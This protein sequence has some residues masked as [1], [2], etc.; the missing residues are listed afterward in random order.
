LGVIALGLGA[1]A[2][3]ES[4]SSIPPWKEEFFKNT[5]I[6]IVVLTLIYLLVHCFSDDLVINKNNRLIVSGKT[7]SLSIDSPAATA[8]SY[9]IQYF[10]DIIVHVI[11]GVHLIAAGS[12]II[13]SAVE[14]QQSQD[15]DV[16]ISAG[17]RTERNWQ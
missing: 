9:S 2:L 4:P 14:I 12:L 11:G 6:T 8:S 15:Y 16:K 13:R 10:Q 1:H 5:L 3:R 7:N 17:V